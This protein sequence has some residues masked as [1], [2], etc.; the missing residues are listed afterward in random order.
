MSRSDPA[1]PWLDSRP[2]SSAGQA[3]GGAVLGG[4]SMQIQLGA[5]ALDV[6]VGQTFQSPDVLRIR[7]AIH[8]ADRLSRVT[9]DFVS[10]RDCDDVALVGL[11]MLLASIPEGEIA[12]RGLTERQWRLL[13]YVGLDPYRR[14]A[15]SGRPAAG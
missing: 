13:N 9:I 2:G 12:V 4:R 10:A 1:G 15:P 3:A 6:R 8:Q 11:A 5:D 14:D 7:Q